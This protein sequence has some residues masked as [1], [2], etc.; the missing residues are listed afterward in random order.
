MGPNLR[1][2][3]FT[4][5]MRSRLRSGGGPGRLGMRP[6]V[7]DTQERIP[8]GHQIAFWPFAKS[9]AAGGKSTSC[10]IDDF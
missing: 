10:F 9:F 7:G 4:V 3:G 5:G 1:F 2:A 8:S 6:G